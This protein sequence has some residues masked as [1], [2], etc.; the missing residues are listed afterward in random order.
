MM[1]SIWRKV[2]A[3]CVAAVLFAGSIAQ[4]AEAAA[5]YQFKYKS[6]TVTMH[7]AAKKFLK[8]AGKAQKTKVKK[9]C[10]YKGKDRTYQYKDFIFYTYSKSAKGAEYVMG[11]TFRT[12]KVA[13]KEGVKIGSPET[14]VTKKYGKAK[15]KFGIYTYKKGK[16]KVQ[17]EVTNNVVTNIRYT[18]AK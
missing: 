2:G 7:S 13:T 4:P 14:M 10:A 6:V 12:N 5:G 3:V 16:S 9:S 1:K 18:T 11:I 8:K 15:P 17:F